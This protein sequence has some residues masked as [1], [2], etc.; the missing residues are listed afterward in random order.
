MNNHNTTMWSAHNTIKPTIRS[1][2]H[3][4][5]IT[6]LTYAKPIPEVTV[7]ENI[8]EN[9]Y[10]DLP[11][12]DEMDQRHSLPI[13]SRKS[14]E[15]IAAI[16]GSPSD[17][18]MP[19]PQITPNT[20]ASREKRNCKF[21]ATPGDS[22][23]SATSLILAPSPYVESKFLDGSRSMEDLLIRSQEYP[24]ENLVFE[25]GGS[26]GMAYVGA[27]QVFWIRQ[28]IHTYKYI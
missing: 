24:F 25:G 2:K 19:S 4:A 20:M 15:T 22:I 28:Y 11:E 12:I 9:L 5:N 23:V 13:T 7:D 21:R 17:V 27:L 14:T 6:K 1:K 10:E 26:K 18:I 8:P 16:H 3:M